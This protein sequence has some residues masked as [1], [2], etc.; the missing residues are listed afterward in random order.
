MSREAYQ[1]LMELVEVFTDCSTDG[2]EIWCFNYI[3]RIVDGTLAMEE[4]GRERKIVA[5]KQLIESYEWLRSIGITTHYQE[6][7]FSVIS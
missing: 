2:E 1:E 6:E 7:I 3:K 4:I 5:Q